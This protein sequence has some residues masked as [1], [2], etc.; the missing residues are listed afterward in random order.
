MVRSVIQY[1]RE[2]NDMPHNRTRFWVGLAIIAVTIPAV[3]TFY[4]HSAATDDLRGNPISAAGR[5][6]LASRQEDS[7]GSGR[8]AL[9]QPLRDYQAEVN[10]ALA[11]QGVYPDQRFSGDETYDDLFD[12]DP[13]DNVDSDRFGNVSTRESPSPSALLTLGNPNLIA[14][15]TDG[16]VT[17]NGNGANS[18]SSSM[19]AT[20]GVPPAVANASTTASATTV[21]VDDYGQATGN[22][23]DSD[24]Y[25]LVTNNLPTSQRDDFARGYAAM[26]AEQRADLLDG[27]RQQMQGGQ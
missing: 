22:M 24:V 16:P 6:D 25:R 23:S 10:A 27:F 8:L 9:H 12:V 20:N 11:R 3:G 17:D 13:L 7:F 26:S 1:I 15:S 18:D 5:I 19:G 2:T 21:A 14:Y 4:V